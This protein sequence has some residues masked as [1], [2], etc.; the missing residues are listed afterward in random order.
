MQDELEALG[1]C[2]SADPKC[3]GLCRCQLPQLE[4]AA[5]VDCQN[6]FEIANVSGFCYI[7]AAPGEPFV[8]NVDF[9]K[10]CPADR[11]RDLRLLGTGM[12]NKAHGR[13][14]DG[15]EQQQDNLPTY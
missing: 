3:G 1:Q 8:G 6:S 14:W 12:E 2:G 5:L 10:D 9:V 13:T 11:R 7:S 4:G 15:G